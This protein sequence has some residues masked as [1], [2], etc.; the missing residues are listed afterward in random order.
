MSPV[1]LRDYTTGSPFN[2]G[3]INRTV[4]FNGYTWT[5]TGTDT[6]SAAFEINNPDV[7]LTVKNGKI[8]SITA[9]GSDPVGDGRHH[10]LRQRESGV[11]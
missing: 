2:S 5:C 9:R 1:I 7:T 6:N 11:R 10:H 3:T 4:D 8:V